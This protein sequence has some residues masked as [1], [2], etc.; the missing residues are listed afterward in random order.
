MKKRSR[1]IS[2]NS[3]WLVDSFEYHEFTKVDE[4]QKAVFEE[5]VEVSKVRIEF[6][7]RYSRDKKEA[8]VISNAII[9]CFAS[10]TVPLLDFKER[11][12]VVI[13]GKEYLIQKVIPNRAPDGSMW[14]YELEVL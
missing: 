12:K 7:T 10:D 5:P 11:A 3:N 8:K 1:M 4:W 2:V 9:Y 14:S 6:G 13:E